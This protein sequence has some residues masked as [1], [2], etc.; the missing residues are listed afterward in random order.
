VGGPNAQIFSPPYL[1]AGTRPTIASAPTS[2]GYGQTVFVGTPDAASITK[3][4]LLREASVTHTNSMSQSFQSL[5][6]TTTSTGLNVTMPAN[7]NIAPPGYYLLFILN[8]S[9][10]PS[11]ANIVQMSTT[12]ASVG[13]VTGKVTNTAGA[14]ISGASVSSGGN[15][16]ITGS[17][18]VYTLQL[19][20]GT[21]T[22]TAALAGYQNASESV[23]VTAGQTTQAATLQMQ[24]VSPGNVT[25]SVVNSAGTG[26]SGASVAAGGLT[27]TTAA[28]GSYALNDLPAG[29]TTIKASLTGFQSGST[30]VTV[31]AA[32][33]TAAPAITLVSGSGSITG[34]IKTTAGAAIAGA[35][36]GFGGGTATTD[37]NGNYTLTGVPV[38]T[39]QLVASA[40]GFQSVTQSVTVTGGNT[41]T[42]NFTLTAAASTGTVTGKITNASTGG[43]VASA[44]VSWSGGST[45]SN[46][47]GIYTLTNVTAGTQNITAVKTGYLSRTLAV[48][49]TG[50]ATSTLNIP[51]ATAGKISVKVVTSGGAVVSGATVT[52]KGGVIATTVSGSSSSTGLF[53]TNW[54]PIGTYTVT[55]AKSGFTTQSKT[56]SVSS[57]VTTSLTFTGF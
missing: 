49:V 9:G 40:S 23:T 57:G 14:P 8:S 48:G 32:T 12:A 50:G 43:L 3:V 34:S 47:S 18:G 39:V 25:G 31:V 17:D 15:G 28:D 26:L 45:T 13:T 42:A 53:T 22:L 30:T 10:V 54:I 1:F 29:S 52:I 37:A 4:T 6:F 41:S 27:T 44:T 55:V 21:A 5:S 56:A 16:A 19:P 20:D 11:V 36:V 2:A 7:A 46:T 35:S 33:T 51:I 24:P 38:G